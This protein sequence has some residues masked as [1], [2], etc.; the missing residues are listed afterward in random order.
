M[1]RTSD[2]SQRELRKI[3]AYLDGL[4]TP[5]EADAFERSL[6]NDVELAWAL[7]EIRKTKEL[8][9]NLQPLTAPRS[10]ALSPEMAGLRAT[11][12]SL[13]LRY[14]T[15]LAM[16]AFTLTL[17]A[18]LLLNMAG[19]T[20]RAAPAMEVMSDMALESAPLE[21]VG[22]EELP[23]VA[24]MES[25]AE[26]FAVEEPA[27]E[28]PAP[29]MEL[30]DGSALPAEAEADEEELQIM[31]APPDD[32]DRLEET[33]AL[34]AVI[35]ESD[36]GL[37]AQV[38]PETESGDAAAISG[39]A[40]IEDTEENID[41]DPREVTGEQVERSRPLIQWMTPLRAAQILLGSLAIILAGF[42]L[43]QRK[44]A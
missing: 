15:A 43:H 23:A 20:M 5:Q 19:G 44:S 3:S 26:E 8:I 39:K 37:S 35:E 9:G 38:A 7:A 27:A 11:R 14:A 32:T 25:A 42:W 16:L 6:K 33:E 30:P 34:E 4:L 31:A 36:E 22:G 41:I 12:S 21:G 2:L 1:R 13:F 17:G 29:E 18:D 40:L 24:E 10:F 28:S